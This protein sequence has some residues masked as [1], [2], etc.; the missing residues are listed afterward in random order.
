MILQMSEAVKGMLMDYWEFFGFEVV[1]EDPM[2]GKIKMKMSLLC[3][4]KGK[5]NEWVA[6][7]CFPYNW[8]SKPGNRHNMGPSH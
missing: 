5:V 2:V 6:G 8:S 4:R 7:L 3:M 1:V